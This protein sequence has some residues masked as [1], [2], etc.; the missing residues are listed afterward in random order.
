MSRFL[1]F[2]V[3]EN[4]IIFGQTATAAFI[5]NDNNLSQAVR[6]VPQKRKRNN[7]MCCPATESCEYLLDLRVSMNTIASLLRTNTREFVELKRKQND[8]REHN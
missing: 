8:E 5:T 2:F 4:E 3:V 1:T 6:K 7:V